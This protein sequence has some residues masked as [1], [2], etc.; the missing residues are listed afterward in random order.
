MTTPEHQQGITNSGPET[1]NIS[2]AAIGSRSDPAGPSRT[3]R[4]AGPSVR[5]EGVLNLGRGQINME[6]C[7]TGPGATLYIGWNRPEPEAGDMTA[8]DVHGYAAAVLAEPEM[9][10]LT[11]EEAEARYAA[12]PEA[13]PEAEI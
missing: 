8:A 1:V 9:H 2:G 13:E 7:V 11:P 6:G 4:S 3:V 5:N 12:E 10:G